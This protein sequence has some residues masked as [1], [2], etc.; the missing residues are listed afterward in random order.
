[1]GQWDGRTF[2][3]FRRAGKSDIGHPRTQ[4]PSTA[5]PSIFTKPF[6]QLNDQTTNSQT[7]YYPIM[8]VAFTPSQLSI[9]EAT[10]PITFRQSPFRLFLADLVLII[11]LLP[12]AIQIILPFQTDNVN[13]E[14]Y[15]RNARNLISMI[16]HFFLFVCSICGGV[17]A[18]VVFFLIPGV[19]FVVY[20]LAFSC[21]CAVCNFFQK[22]RLTVGI[23]ILNCGSTL[24][25]SD[26]KILQLD[27]NDYAFDYEEW[28]FIN[29]VMA[30]SFWDE[31]AV[32][33]ISRLF[34]RR[35]IGIRNL[36]FFPY[37]LFLTV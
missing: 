32:N 24:V 15:L 13:G 1:M 19:G 28:F 17:L 29:G 25:Q 30:G 10:S 34:E 4:T 21:A 36:T 2:R 26:T 9:T 16:L 6:D 8:P 7:L 5:L 33:E 12:Y 11:R 31:A 20:I 23:L 37:K 35:V 22:P 27:V 14:L 3:P 18:P